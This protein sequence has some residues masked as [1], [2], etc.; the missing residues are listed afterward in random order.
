[1]LPPKKKLF[2][3][4]D[5]VYNPFVKY[6]K[7]SEYLILHRRGEE[8]N[9]FILLKCILKFKFSSLDYCV[10]FIRYVSPKLILTAH[11]YHSIFYRLSRKT[12]IKSLMLQ[13]G[14]RSIID[15]LIKN[16]K[17]FFPKDSKQNFFVDFI[18]LYNQAVVNFYSKYISG[19][20]FKI[21]SFEN[22]F[23]KINNKKKKEI[24][25]ISNFNIS[26]DG[27]LSNK[28]ENED[29]IALQIHKLAQKSKILFNILPRNRENQKKNKI[30]YNYYKKTLKR[31]FNFLNAKGESGYSILNRYKYIFSSYSTMAIEALVKNSRVGF[32]FFKSKNNPCYGLWF[33]SLENFKKKGLFWSTMTNLNLREIERVFNFVVKS[34]E[35]KWLNKTKFYKNLLMNYDK[36]NKTF[37]KILKKEINYK[38]AK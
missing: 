15:G 14:K 33:A 34:S 18:L 2:V 7:K 13:K 38:F 27:K 37:K 10:E 16:Q 5:G 24:L 30:E 17:I 28:S 9:L 12:G 22:N 3:V 23:E 20:F 35:S 19:N 4:V 6:I 32:V 25:F 31:N 29:L 21:G 26:D 8:I 11:D 1:M 36:D